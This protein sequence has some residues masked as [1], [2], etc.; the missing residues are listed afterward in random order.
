VK[1]P[2]VTRDRGILEGYLED[3]SGAPAGVA[4]GLVRPSSVEEAAA[5]LAETAPDGTPIL[6]QAARSSLTGGAIPRDE[7]VLSVESLDSIGRVE[8]TGSGATV[9][10]DAG[11][12][13]DRLATELAASG[14][15]YPPVPTYQQAMIGGTVATN[16]G[17]AAT[18]KYGVTRDWVRGIRL[19]LYDG[20]LLELE[21]GQVVAAA[22]EPFV[23]HRDDG[24]TIEFAAPRYRLPPLKKISAGYH[25][26]PELDLVDLFV[27]SEGTLGLITSIRL[28]LVPLPP[29]VVTGLVF[30]GSFDA[31]LALA[32]SL[33]E[34]AM[35]ARR[36]RDT[37]GPDVRAIE[38]VDGN[39]IDLLRASGEAARLRVTIPDGARAAVLFETELP[40]RTDN[41]R[42]EQ[43]VMRVLEGR[44]DGGDDTAVSRLFR[45]LAEHDALDTLEFAFPE[46]AARRRA[47]FDFREAVPTRVNELLAER[48]RNH[49]GVKKVAGDLIVPFD[50]LAGIV[51]FYE[52]AFRSR[53]LEYAIW[54][55]LSD[56]NLHPNALARSRAEVRA[57]QDA[58]FE[59][60]AE[61]VA[62]GGCPLSEH[63]VGRDPVKQELLRRFLGEDAVAEM[64]AIKHAL[65]PPR[66]FGR[67]VLFP[68]SGSC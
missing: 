40:E 63:G 29:S 46:D 66:R 50:R 57:G 2:P 23:V 51:P 39:G 12:R 35:R 18:F 43:L 28:G 59:C 41:A 48:R 8:R 65:D 16:A 7:L 52:R 22:G 33:R 19:L 42:V 54:G 20:E 17:G 5:I 53:G 68:D 24:G 34:A 67:G 56:G 30:L 44:E 60:A 27:G 31:A 61:A 15:Y 45:L 37:R 58:V 32:S 49:P 36:Q 3:A 26:A 55:H 13:L 62:A 6:L 9:W 47:L 64:R 4:T 38:S 11:V 21:R 14:W 25:A 1:A 10:V